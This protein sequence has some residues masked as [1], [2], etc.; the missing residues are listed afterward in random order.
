MLVGLQTPDRV[1]MSKDSCLQATLPVL[2]C[3]ITHE[4][5]LNSR[6]TQEIFA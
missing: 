6:V 3:G 2:V 4:D 1:V 5:Y